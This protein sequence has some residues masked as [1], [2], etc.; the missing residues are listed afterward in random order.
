MRKPLM[1]MAVLLTIPAWAATPPD[2]GLRRA[3]LATAHIRTQAELGHPIRFVVRELSTSGDWAFLHASMQEANGTAVD[4]TGTP[5][6]EAASRGHKSP[7]YAALMHGE[8]GHWTIVTDS[9]GPTDMA[10]QDWA[11]RYHAPADL[12]PMP[13][14]E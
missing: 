13:S 2:P 11:S 12:F 5:Y 8:H 3:L 9:V 4:Y 7:N 10:W 14:G 1:L 6:A